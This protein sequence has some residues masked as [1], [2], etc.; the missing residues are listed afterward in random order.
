MPSL[1]SYWIA[2][3][4]RAVTSFPEFIGGNWQG[5]LLSLCYLAVKFARW[6]RAYLKLNPF[7][8]DWKWALRAVDAGRK[9]IDWRTVVTITGLFFLGNVLKTSYE[10]QFSIWTAREYL[11]E[12]SK[13]EAD[14]A[15]TTVD[16]LKMKI[17]EQSNSCAVKD[18]INQTLQKQNIDQQSSINGCLS[19]AMKLLT[20]ETHE[21]H[22]VP[23]DDDQSNQV[24]KM[25]SWIAL[26][27][28]PVTP[29]KNVFE[30]HEATPEKGYSDSSFLHTVTF[31]RATATVLGTA[32]IGGG[33]ERIA[34][35]AWRLNISSPAWTKNTPMK[36]TVWYR[37]NASIGC[38]V[39]P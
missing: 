25:A 19:Q 35:N 3:F 16:N 21:I 34:Q 10:D 6:V 17:T 5:V 31:L 1:V 24:D 7:T 14:A 30:C 13:H 20:P 36:V 26:T 37:G 9:Q 39:N 23:L 22:L 27:N 8:K 4:A 12:S 32:N 29:V 15:K 18:G 11:R 28:L 2:V 38:A 33:I